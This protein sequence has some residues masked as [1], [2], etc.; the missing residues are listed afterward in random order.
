MKIFDETIGEMNKFFEE[1]DSI[2]EKL[3]HKIITLEEYKKKSHEFKISLRKLYKEK[4]SSPV[5]VLKIFKS[6]DDLA[7]KNSDIREELF[8]WMTGQRNYS[9]IKLRQICKI[10]GFNYWLTSDN[11]DIINAINSLDT[12]KKRRETK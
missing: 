7:E 11:I 12:T 6:F 5:T 4:E 2:L 8:I 1:T 10:A 9:T 3:N